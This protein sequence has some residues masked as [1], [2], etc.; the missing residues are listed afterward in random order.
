MKHSAKRIDQAAGRRIALLAILSVA[1][2]LASNQIVFAGDQEGISGYKFKIYDPDGDGIDGNEGNNGP[3]GSALSGAEIQPTRN[4]VKRDVD[5]FVI[6]YQF[7]VWIW[8][9]FSD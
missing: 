1:L 9:W 6:A 3:G 4:D 7:R 5:F 2:F 8:G